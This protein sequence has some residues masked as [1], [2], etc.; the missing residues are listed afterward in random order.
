MLKLQ[1]T[2]ASAEIIQRKI[3]Y[4]GAFYRVDQLVLRH[5]L[6]EGGW[7]PAL[8]REVMNQAS[9]VAVLLVDPILQQLVLIEQF[10]VGAFIGGLNA[11]KN[12]RVSSSAFDSS[13]SPWLIEIVAGLI[14]PGESLISV[15]QRE[16]VEETG[17]NVTALLPICDYW[18]SPAG[19]TGK[20]SLFCGQVDSKLAAGIHGVAADGED[21]R[22]HVVPIQNAYYD[23]SQG[24]IKHGPTLIALQW[25]QL[26]EKW[27]YEQWKSG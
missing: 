27:V 22:L 14:E 15:A 7:S 17:L 8:H 20:I 16:T 21:I 25:L 10:R 4:Q 13:D 9:A 24:L 23:L 18:M 12:R 3:A 6:F 26:H 1:F 19:S 2:A 11:E 5:A